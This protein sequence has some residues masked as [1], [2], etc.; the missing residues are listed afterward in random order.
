MIHNAVQ[1]HYASPPPL[2]F[3]EVPYC[4]TSATSSSSLRPISVHTLLGL[5]GHIC[6][7][8]IYR[9]VFPKIAV[10]MVYPKMDGL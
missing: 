4:R 7:I 1:Q 9:W 6:Y 3:A 5:V 2:I 8:F 10:Y